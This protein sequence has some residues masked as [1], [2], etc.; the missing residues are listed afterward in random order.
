MV[1]AWMVVRERR[2]GRDNGGKDHGG[3]TRTIV[4]FR[5]RAVK[6]AELFQGRITFRPSREEPPV[7]VSRDTQTIQLWQERR[8]VGSGIR[9]GFRTEDES[10]VVLWKV[11]QLQGGCFE[12]IQKR[13]M[14]QSEYSEDK[15]TYWREKSARHS[16]SESQV[17]G[18]CPDN[19]SST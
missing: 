13:S 4:F 19:G 17:M 6:G 16:T 18:G 3:G 5:W 10:R 11:D 7:D 15:P 2:A 8:K 9:Q 14:C 12:L 1:Y